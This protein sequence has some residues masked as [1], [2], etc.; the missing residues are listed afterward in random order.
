MSIEEPQ[1]VRV[2][3]RKDIEKTLTNIDRIGDDTYAKFKNKQIKLSKYLWEMCGKLV[4]VLDATQFSHK[5]DYSHLHKV[6]GD[7][8]IN[9]F[10]YVYLMSDW[11]KQ[12]SEEDNNDGTNMEQC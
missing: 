10:S 12:L 3:S 2:K 4:D 7:D 11:I 8:G 9:Y 6:K 1:I 5:Y